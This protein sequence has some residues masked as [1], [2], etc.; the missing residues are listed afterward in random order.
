[1]TCGV[2]A[3]VAQLVRT[4]S[5]HKIWFFKSISVIWICSMHRK[6]LCVSFIVSLL[7]YQNW[8]TNPWLLSNFLIV[9][10]EYSC[11]N[12][13]YF[14]VK[15]TKDYELVYIYSFIRFIVSC[16]KPY[17]QYSS[18]MYVT[19]FFFKIALNRM[20]TNN[21]HARINIIGVVWVDKVFSVQTQI[22]I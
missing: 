20:C 12:T 18:Y 6:Y 8:N 21:L 17:R 7:Y 14:H 5:Y 16:F 2:T 10:R 15:N 4:C 1:M 22:I 11:K 13:L 3:A 9:M 19:V